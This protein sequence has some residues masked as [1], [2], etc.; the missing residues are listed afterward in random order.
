MTIYEYDSLMH[1]I[2]NARRRKKRALQRG[3]DVAYGTA[4]H[5]EEMADY[6]LGR[7]VEGQKRITRSMCEK[8]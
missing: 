7:L 3:D 1:A 5:D 8:N 6:A 4:Q 2:R